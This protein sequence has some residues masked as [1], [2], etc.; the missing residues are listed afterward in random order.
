MQNDKHVTHIQHQQF[1]K[2]LGEL[3]HEANEPNHSPQNKLKNM[4]SHLNKKWSL[5]HKLQF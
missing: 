2:D 4:I 5:S 3:K 1:R